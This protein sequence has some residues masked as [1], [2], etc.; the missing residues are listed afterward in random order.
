[1]VA[2]ETIRL[3]SKMKLLAYGA[4]GIAEVRV[5]EDGGDTFRAAKVGVANFLLEEPNASQIHS[6]ERC[7]RD[8]TGDLVLD[9]PV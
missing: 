4:V 1:M 2:G 8:W 5:A 7:S 6:V 9:L 3:P